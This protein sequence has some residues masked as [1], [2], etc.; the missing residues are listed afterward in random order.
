MDTDILQYNENSASINSDLLLDFLSL[1]IMPW[2]AALFS[3]GWGLFCKYVS[4]LTNLN[5]DSTLNFLSFQ[6]AQLAAFHR[7][8]K[9]GE[10]QS[11]GLQRV[12]HGWLTEQQRPQFRCSRGIALAKSLQSCLNLCDPLASLFMGFSRQG[13]WSGLSFLPPGILPKPGI[14]PTS[15]TPPSWQVD[16]LPLVPP[17]K[18]LRGSL[19]T[20]M[21]WV[22]KEVLCPQGSS[23]NPPSVV[24][25]KLVRA[26]S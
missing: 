6:G 4:L 16:S 2:R 3:R 13:Y 8:G 5:S 19:I 11:M 20:L 22:F 9:P 7:T 23:D 25:P 15:L 18:S 17:G 12:G 10:V 21:V 14:E 1:H 24:L 26:W